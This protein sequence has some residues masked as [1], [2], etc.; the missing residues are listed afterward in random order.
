MIGYAMNIKGG[1]V[2]PLTKEAFCGLIDSPSV[3]ATVAEIT[4]GWEKEKRGEM[5]RDDFETFKKA[6]KAKLP[7]IT[8]HAT[9]SDGKRDEAHAVPSGL[10]MLDIDHMEGSPRTFYEEA[11]KPRLGELAVLL[12]HV[13]PSGEGLRLVAVLPVGFDIVR[14]QAW[15]AAEL[16][17]IA[18]DAKTKDL[19]RASFVV[20]RDYVLHV[21]DRLFEPTAGSLSPRP[22]ADPPAHAGQQAAPPAHA[23]QQATEASYPS[24]YH[25]VAYTDI[26]AALVEQLGGAPEHGDRNN[27][28]FILACHL[29]HICDDAPAWIKQ[30]IPTFGEAR[31]RAF[32]TV[33]SAC[34]RKQSG[35]MTE[36]VKRAI[37]MAKSLLSPDAETSEESDQ[38]GTSLS[39]LLSPQKNCRRQFSAVSPACPRASASPS[40]P[41]CCPSR[42]HWPTRW[43]PNTATGSAWASG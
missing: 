25:G 32:A 42:A 14:A 16:G 28:I 24:H 43:R 23:G 33:D 41:A 8:P 17:G 12:A 39:S 36:A 31:P 2:R 29:R 37:N 27:F 40:S 11:V 18:Y 38:Q 20:P 35:Q 4:D 34:Q 26:V 6:R 5:S 3:G 21:D 10:Y 15:L 19:A 9:F 22:Q 1:E 30:L 13:T 7:F